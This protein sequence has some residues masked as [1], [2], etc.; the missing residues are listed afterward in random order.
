MVLWT[1][2]LDAV[3]EVRGSIAMFMFIIEE[4]MQGIG[5]ANWIAYKAEDW[6][7]LLSNV[8]YGRNQLLIPALDF[9]QKYGAVAYPLNLAYET[10]YKSFE[11]SLDT[12]EKEALK[13]I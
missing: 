10:F 7:L 11:K 2:A 6:E 12:M 3:Q 8:Q 4:S 1:I 9:V 5:M 13:H